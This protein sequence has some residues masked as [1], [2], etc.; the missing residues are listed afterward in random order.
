[1][2]QFETLFKEW[3]I[4]FGLSETYSHTLYIVASILIIAI[5]SIISN[6]VAK[7]II[8]QTISRVIKKSKATWDDILLQRK[9]F[10]RLSHLAPAIVIFY[11]IA[12]AFPDAPEWVSIIRRGTYIYMIIIT[13][14]I[15]DSFVNALH[16]IYNE[17]PISKERPIT[18]YIQVVQILLYFIGFIVVI[19]ILL[20]KSP[21][22]LFAGLGALAAV[23][24]LVFKDSILG[25]VAGIQ[26]SLNKMV[27]IGDWITMPSQN[28]DGDV[29]EIT[30][31]TVKVQNF[32]K[33]ITT[34]PT[35]ALISQS[36][37]NWRGMTD[38]DGRRI[39]RSLNIDIQSI[40]FCTEEQLD[41]LE[42]VHVISN[43]IKERRKEIADY[44]KNKNVDQSVMA[45]GRRLTNIGVF[46]KYAESYLENHPHIN[47]DMTFLVRQLQTTE[48][49]VPIEIYVFSNEQRWVEYENIQSDIF[50]HLLAAIKVFKLSIYQN[51]SSNDLRHLIKK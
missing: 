37:N 2:Q 14:L 13:I 44:N 45:N 34:I 8:L 51:P 24:M 41:E 30:L 22:A 3:L 33:T 5:V 21:G 25:L 31:N 46:R 47:K 35:Y 29:I 20:G 43:Y 28:A 50:D 11:L 38:S 49:G 23:L 18:G 36:F 42:K 39:K 12:Q 27:S 4:S 40:E 6:W 15:I 10:N 32:D 7:T 9:V 17:K 19:A 16:E 1:M 48:T 26:L